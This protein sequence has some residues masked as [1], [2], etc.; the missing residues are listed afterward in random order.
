VFVKRLLNRS[1]TGNLL[2]EVFGMTTAFV[3]LVVV[4]V[5]AFDVWLGWRSLRSVSDASPPI[6]KVFRRNRSSLLALP[7][8]RSVGIGEVGGVPCIVVF[9]R[10]LTEH[11]SSDVPARLD[12]WEVRRQTVDDERQDAES[13]FVGR[14]GPRR[15]R[16]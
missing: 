9:A 15:V 14:R 5:C 11:E 6:E 3:I 16:S 13:R 4:G 7:G 10:E 2:V 1:V 12:G 8:V